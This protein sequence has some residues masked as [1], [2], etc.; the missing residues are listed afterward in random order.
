MNVKILVT[1]HN[2]EFIGGSVLVFDSLR[3]GF[4]DA[5]VTV[6]LNG[7]KDEFN[8]PIRTAAE[9]AGVDQFV[10]I[11]EETIHHKWIERL[12]WTETEPFFLCDTDVVFWKEFPPANF[13]RT[14]AGCYIPA[15]VDKFTNAK[16][17]PRL[18][19]SLLYV[20]PKGVQRD[21]R[22]VHVWG[23]STRFNPVINLVYPVQIPYKNENVFYDTCALLYQAI[24][25][26]E[27]TG[28]QLECYD[29]LN[30]GTWVDELDKAYPELKLPEF[31][32]SVYKNPELA[33]GIRHMQNAFYAAN[34]PAS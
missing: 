16:T 24:G 27:F 30:A 3:I 10:V 14:L 19:T 12:I 23:R 13:T 21:A 33:R 18:H 9:N 26:Q 11:E 32:K 15:F 29:H 5:R 22:V 1:C 20:N 4:P 25:G 8:A 7:L 31:H 28:Y 17:M 6:Y 2:A 34:Y